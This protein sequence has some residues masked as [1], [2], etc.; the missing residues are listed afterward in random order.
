MLVA[1]AGVVVGEGPLRLLDLACGCGSISSR[2]LRRFP[3]A[4]IVALDLDPVLLRIAAG[5]FAG[6]GRISLVE[7]DLR[8]PRWSDSLPSGQ[9]DAVVSATALHWLDPG[10]LAAVHAALAG[11]IRPGGLF[12]DSDQ[13]PLAA[14][15]GLD[16]AAANLAPPSGS[17]GEGWEEWWARVAAAPELAD[18][19]PERN[20]RFGGELHPAEFT[21]SA[22][23]HRESLAAA[24]FAEAAVVWRR[25]PAAVLAA[26]R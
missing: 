2:V 8:D 6:D 18:L 12:A 22:D 14:T 4:Q 21:P 11:L 17:Q 26:L 5:V 16:L 3:N 1:L 25:G 7:V 13:I 19:L 20:R 24:G 23:W 10:A 9:F 15:P